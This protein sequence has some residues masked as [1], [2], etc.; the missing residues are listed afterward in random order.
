MSLPL[1]NPR[2][3][4]IRQLLI[5]IQGA[6]TATLQAIVELL[7]TANAT[8]LETYNELNDLGDMLVGSLNLLEEG[9]E[10]VFPPIP[11]LKIIN[12]NLVTTAGQVEAGNTIADQ[13]RNSLSTLATG[14]NQFLSEWGFFSLFIGRALQDEISGD[15]L[16][17]IAGRIDVKLSDAL[18]L[19]TEIRDCACDGGGS[20]TPEFPQGLCPAFGIRVPVLG[21][22]DVIGTPGGGGSVAYRWNLD[23]VALSSV[24]DIAVTQDATFDFTWFA[25]T[26]TEGPRQVCLAAASSALALGGTWALVRQ[27]VSI[28]TLPSGVGSGA[29]VNLAGLNSTGE[30]TVSLEAETVEP[31]TRAWYS[32]QLTVPNDVD[33]LPNIPGLWVNFGALG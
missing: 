19:L 29:V 1:F 12:D 17:D 21:P 5:A 10:P 8:T 31:G 24:A 9:G 32:V 11:W 13:S 22:Q 27:T 28:G 7:T 16:A 4:Q 23:S 25:S 20:G 30:Q 33:P 2:L 6:D 26:L 3:E 15:P 18:T 14:F